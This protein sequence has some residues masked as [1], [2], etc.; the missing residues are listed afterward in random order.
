MEQY[1]AY[2]VRQLARLAG[3]SVRTLHHYDQIG[4]L[5][6]AK[7]TPSGYRLYRQPDLQRLQQILFYK[8]L[9]V[10]LEEIRRLL[11]QPGFDPISTLEDHRRSLLMRRERL[12]QL[13]QTIDKTIRALKGENMELTDEELYE[14]FTQE[15]RERYDREVKEMYDPE[16]VAE[17]HRRLRKLTKAQWQAVKEE[18]G[19][20]TLKLAE[21]S[22]RPI[23]DPE[24]QAAIARHHSWIENF[25]TCSA[26][27]YQGLGRLYSEHPEFR[28]MY[29][30]IRPGLADYMREAMAYYAAHVLEK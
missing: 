26:E 29:E 1:Q 22:D 5:S 8:E 20:V 2:T 16:L 4:L 25:Y 23:H 18:G 3:I 13:L 7:R 15:Q 14:G 10:P 30:K 21:L 19:A 11:D 12:D 24:V 6:P 17:S 27:V 28:A 9:E